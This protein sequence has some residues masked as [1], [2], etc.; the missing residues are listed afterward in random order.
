MIFGVYPGGEA[1]TVGP[2]EARY[3][4]ILRS[5]S[6]RSSA[7]GPPDGPSS[8]TSMR[9]TRAPTPPSAAD[10]VGAQH[11]RVHGGAAS[12]SSSSRPTAPPAAIRPQRRGLR[13]LRRASR[14][15]LRRQSRLRRAPGHQRGEHPQRPERRRRLLPGATDALVE[16]V[17][18]A[19]RKS[20]QRLLAD[21]VG[22]N[23]AYSNHAAE[24][25]SGATWATAGAT[26]RSP[27]TGSGSTSIPGPGARAATGGDLAAR[28]PRRWSSRS[29][30]CAMA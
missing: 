22:F 26:F 10:Q 12:R 30:R 3:R 23:W 27:S 18:A 14:S 25:T 5:G 15:E 6:P 21:R 20:K 2:Q 13:R 4:R 19:R 7:Y 8:F 1:G 16:G 28:R 29:R 17:K 11:R 9:A 24:A